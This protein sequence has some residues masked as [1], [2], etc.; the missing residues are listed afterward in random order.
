MPRN[1]GEVKPTGQA[2]RSPEG[3][4][5]CVQRAALARAFALAAAIRIPAL[6]L[7]GGIESTYE[8]PGTLSLRCEISG[9]DSRIQLLVPADGAPAV[10]AA[11]PWLRLGPLAPSGL[12]R[13]AA[14]PLGYSAGSD[15]F[16]EP[17]R[18][19]L[20]MSIPCGGIGFLFMPADESLGLFWRE[21]TE[22]IGQ[23]GFFASVVPGTGLR[24]EGFLSVS[25][26]QPECTGEGWY[27]TSLPYPG[28][29]LFVAA[30]RLLGEIPPGVLSATIGASAGENVAPASF[31]HLQLSAEA[32]G[33]R[34]SLLFGRVD[35][36]YRSPSGSSSANCLE[37]AGAFAFAFPVGSASLR[38]SLFLRQPGFAPSLFI[39]TVEKVE[40]GFERVLARESGGFA[41]AGIEAAKSVTRDP[42]GTRTDWALCGVTAKGRWGR[43][44]LESR[45][46]L[47][48]P[49]RLE[50]DFAA[51]FSAARSETRV[52]FDV[53]ISVPS[54]GAPALTATASLKRRGRD[55]AISLKAGIG[56]FSP[57]EDPGDRLRL[58]VSWSAR[59]QFT[60]AG[61]PLLAPGP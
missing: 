25:R 50:V 52:S 60:R 7:V 55:S 37:A 51:A 54:S 39:G 9:G 45:A 34:A 21:S 32:P 61:F 44:E 11:F 28:G 46:S 35:R 36:A 22:G 53:G 43:F 17:T 48:L 23:V 19:L 58:E 8:W 24:G 4:L 1:A 57:G 6:P 40:I 13:E 18:L 47:E 56:G 49:G 10:G 31:L 33:A 42:R 38:C 20:D 2:R 29:M 3:Y 14:N 27:A 26:P 16:V 15:V 30:T 12:L 5:H 41:S 59:E